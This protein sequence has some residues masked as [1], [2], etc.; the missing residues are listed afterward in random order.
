MAGPVQPILQQAARTQV[1]PGA[2]P[3]GNIIVA[4][5]PTGGQLTKQVTLTLNKC[6]SVV[7]AGV[8]GVTEVNVKLMPVVPMLPALAEDKTTGPLATL[9]ANPNCYKQMFISAQA[10]LVIE[11]PQGLGLVGVQV[12]EK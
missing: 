12:Y 4:N 11:V 10:N 5:F 1:P 7:A 9:G 6:Y 2:K 3:V 8:P